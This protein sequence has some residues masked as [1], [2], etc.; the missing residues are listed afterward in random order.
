MPRLLTAAAVVALMLPA[1]APAAASNVEELRETARALFGT[2][3]ATEPEEIE[4]PQAQLGQA[5]FWDMR[6]SISGDVACASCHF[7]ENWG[8]DS[9]V[10]SI[11]ARGGRTCNRRLCSIQWKRRA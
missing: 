6:L 2:V 1:V 7:A 8:S 11:N 10:A 3:R 4:D 5:L 9:R